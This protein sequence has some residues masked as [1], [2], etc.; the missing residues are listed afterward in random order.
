VISKLTD[1]PQTSV[2]MLDAS[3]LKNKHGEVNSI[4]CAT[5]LYELD[6]KVQIP[7][8]DGGTCQ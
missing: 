8:L 7:Y 4:V 2:A 1:I 6:E 3:T 5:F